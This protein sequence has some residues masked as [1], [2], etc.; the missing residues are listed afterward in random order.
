MFNL[1]TRGN[2][3]LASIQNVSTLIATF[4]INL[5]NTT[6][7]PEEGKRINARNVLYNNVAISHKIDNVQHIVHIKNKPLVQAFRE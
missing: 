1:T 5:N 6:N 3:R 2:L 4:T 7:H